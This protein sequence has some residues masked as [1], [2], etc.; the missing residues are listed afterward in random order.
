MLPW[1]RKRKRVDDLERPNDEPHSSRTKGNDPEPF[2]LEVLYQPEESCQAS[3][4]LVRLIY[5]T[6]H[7]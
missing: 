1:Q 4:E 6:Y 2:G 7:N 3:Y 5:A